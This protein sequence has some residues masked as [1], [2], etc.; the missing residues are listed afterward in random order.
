MSL[1]PNFND[2]SEIS[3]RFPKDKESVSM[4]LSQKNHYRNGIVEPKSKLQNIRR[5]KGATINMT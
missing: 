5:K 2:T 1:A 3:L 4:P